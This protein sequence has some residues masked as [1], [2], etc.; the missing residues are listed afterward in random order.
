MG[1]G[2]QTPDNATG[3]PRR[4]RGAGARR[5]PVRRPV[6][7]PATYYNT[8]DLA[9]LLPDDLAGQIRSMTTAPGMFLWDNGRGYRML[10][11][12]LRTPNPIVDQRV[13]R[14][15]ADSGS[16]LA[17]DLFVIIADVTNEYGR[18]GVAR[19]TFSAVAD[20][21]TMDVIIKAS[22]VPADPNLSPAD[23]AS[24]EDIDKTVRKLLAD[25]ICQ[26]LRFD[27]AVADG[28]YA[29]AVA[30]ALRQHFS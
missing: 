9:E 26:G 25:D 4:Q 8:S 23:S 27:R 11:M 15:L 21:P 1:R 28:T 10:E 17:G 6:M 3:I 19:D 18:A 12:V 20:P 16:I 5:I 7:S 13:R 22:V 29:N 2:A 14:V 30:E 24:A